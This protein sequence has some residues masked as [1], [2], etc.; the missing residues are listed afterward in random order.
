VLCVL[1]AGQLAAGLMV[2]RPSYIEDHLPVREPAAH[3]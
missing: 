2:A 3:R 1:V